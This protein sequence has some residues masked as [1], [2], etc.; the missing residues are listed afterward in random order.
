MSREQNKK[1]QESSEKKIQRIAK[2][3][4]DKGLT[5][6]ETTKELQKELKGLATY[7]AKRIARFETIGGCN[8]ASLEA[9]K[10]VSGKINKYWIYTHDS[11]TRKTHRHAG[12]RYNKTSPI[13]INEKFKVGNTELM[14]PADRNGDKKEIFNCRCTVGYVRKKEE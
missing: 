8:L 1:I 3:A 13:G 5:I 6:A 7:R 10:Q 14:Y 12:A 9:A 4:I 11:R 2:K